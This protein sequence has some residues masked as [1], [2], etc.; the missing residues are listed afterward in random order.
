MKYTFNEVM[1]VR[2][3]LT[4]LLEEQKILSLTESEATTLDIML[5]E[6]NE[7]ADKIAEENT[8]LM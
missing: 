7:I 8:V 3:T 4:Y 5:L 2:D 6:V 1:K